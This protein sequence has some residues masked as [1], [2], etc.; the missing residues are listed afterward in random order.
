MHVLAALLDRGRERQ[1][2]REK[3]RDKRERMCDAVRV[4]VRGCSVSRPLVEKARAATEL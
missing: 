4:D 3:T 2:E 1:R